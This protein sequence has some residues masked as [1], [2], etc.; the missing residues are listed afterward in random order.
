MDEASHAT[1]DRA[2]DRRAFGTRP[3]EHAADRRA[4]GTRPEDRAK[5]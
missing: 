5:K 2:A 1:E 3:E 4:F